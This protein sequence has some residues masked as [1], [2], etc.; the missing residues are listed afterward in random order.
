MTG[1]AAGRRRR[2]LDLDPGP[3]PGEPL[4]PGRRHVSAVYNSFRVLPDVVGATNATWSYEV[5]LPY[6]DQWTMLGDRGRHGRTV[7]PP[8]RHRD[9][10]R[11]LHRGPTDR[12]DH[13]AGVGDPADEPPCR[14]R[15]PPGSPLTFSG[16]AAD[17]DTLDQVSIS[18][19]NSTTR[20]NLG[21]GLLLGHYGHRRQLPGLPSAHQRRPRTTG[22]TRRRSTSGR[23]PTRSRCRRPTTWA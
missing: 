3:R 16:S 19:R 21:V 6:E 23:G 14:S 2:E 22:P 18:I 12:D 7:R 8:S 13:D 10:A 17:D 15:W 5:T 4:P 11:E 20:E 1:T 9:L